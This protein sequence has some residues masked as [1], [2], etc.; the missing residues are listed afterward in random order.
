MPQ[1]LQNTIDFIKIKSGIEPSQ[2]NEYNASYTPYAINVVNAA[3]DRVELLYNCWQLAVGSPAEIADIF[4]YLTLGINIAD[5]INPVRAHVAEKAMFRC[6]DVTYNNEYK[7][8]AAAYLAAHKAEC[9]RRGYDTKPSSFYVSVEQ[10]EYSAGATVDYQFEVF[11]LPNKTTIV[12]SFSCDDGD[13]D[14]IESD[15]IE[16][17]STVERIKKF[18]IARRDE[19]EKELIAL[20]NIVNTIEHNDVNL[21]DH[22]T[23]PEEDEEDEEEEDE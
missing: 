20:N 4:D 14:D 1:A 7:E 17:L 16:N 18:I 21:I 12:T 15:D 5:Y 13:V 9:I 3:D 11:T 19:T 23:R 10:Y 2:L 8:S 22:I 6:Y